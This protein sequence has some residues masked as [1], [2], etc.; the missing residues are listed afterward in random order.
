M[1]NRTQRHKQYKRSMYTVVSD[2]EWIT[3]W[4]EVLTIF[5]D[6]NENHKHKYRKK[7]TPPLA[8]HQKAH[9]KDGDWLASYLTLGSY[10][11]LYVVHQSPIDVSIDILRLQS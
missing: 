6:E 5:F 3:I 10:S 1:M 7:F 8:A 4:L 2:S 11:R 9:E